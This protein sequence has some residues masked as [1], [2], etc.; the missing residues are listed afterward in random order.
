MSTLVIEKEIQVNDV[1]SERN[2]GPPLYSL[3]EYATTNVT[4]TPV[5]E[6]WLVK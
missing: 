2:N 3:V 1:D 4:G 5:R 6:R